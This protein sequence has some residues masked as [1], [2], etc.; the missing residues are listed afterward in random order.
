MPKKQSEISSTKVKFAPG[1]NLEAVYAAW[2]QAVEANAAKQAEVAAVE[3]AERRALLAACL[4]LH[5]AHAAAPHGKKLD[6][7]ERVRIS[8]STARTH[9]ALASVYLLAR[10]H[11]AEELAAVEADGKFLSVNQGEALKEVYDWLLESG[12]EENLPDFAV[13]GIVQAAKE[14]TNPS[15]I[16]K[17]LKKKQAEMNPPED[18]KIDDEPSVKIVERR[19]ECPRFAVVG[20]NYDEI[21]ASLVHLLNDRKAFVQACK[22]GLALIAAMPEETEKVKAA[23]KGSASASSKSSRNNQG[24][25][26]RKNEA[27]ASD[28]KPAKAE[29]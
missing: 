29:V 9:L 26:K 24:L 22:S 7:Y 5:A 16:Q 11:A 2:R 25:S 10:E 19:V 1:A 17:L 20:R 8:E 15:D 21:K 4:E 27:P 12:L 23:A 13:K 18:P 3:A 28:A 6:V 14:Q